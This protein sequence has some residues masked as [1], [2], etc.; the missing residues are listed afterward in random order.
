MLAVNVQTT[1]GSLELSAE[2]SAD[3]GTTVIIGPNGAGKSSLLRSI[4]GV[5]KPHRGT[6]QLGDRV[7]F[8]QGEGIDVPTDDRRIGYV[9]Q[10]YGLFT[11]MTVFDNIAFGVRNLSKKMRRARVM[12]LLDDLGIAHLA[13]RKTPQLSGGESQRVALARALAIGPDALLLDEPTAALDARA[14]RKV[15]EFL[16]SRLR[17][18]GIPTLVVSHDAEDVASLGG[19]IAVLEGGRIIQLGSL[20]ALRADPATP[21]VRE[22]LADAPRSNP[23][24]AVSEIRSW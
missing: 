4:L 20:E 13:D 17:A 1:V 2:L 6:M 3:S 9:P 14:R 5:L 8:D 7:L 10:S 11:R 19:R 16:S 12:A 22:F 18:I 23:Q 24:R 15:R 21:F